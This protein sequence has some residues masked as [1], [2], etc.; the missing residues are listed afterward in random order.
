MNTAFA[1]I[2]ILGLGVIALFV[3][4]FVAIKQSEDEET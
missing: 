2:T 1:I 3:G 4:A